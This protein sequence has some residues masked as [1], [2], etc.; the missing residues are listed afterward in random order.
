MMIGYLPVSKAEP[1]AESRENLISWYLTEKRW[2]LNEWIQVEVASR[3]SLEQRR[4]TELLDKAELLD[5]VSLQDVVIASAVSRLGRFLKEGLPILQTLLQEKGCRLILLKQ[6]LDLNPANTD[7]R[8]NKILLTVFSLMAEWERD[9]V[10]ERMREGLRPRVAMG[11]KLGKLKGTI[12]QS[13]YD[14]DKEQIL[15]LYA[16]GVPVAVII[17][18]HLPYGTYAS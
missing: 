10:S 14:K 16:L 13:I 1:S 7:D 9:F 18:K 17:N 2:R 12:Q 3:T 4:I 11:L 5:K 15:H 6:G 8:T